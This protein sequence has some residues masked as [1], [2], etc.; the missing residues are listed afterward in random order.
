MKE[1]SISNKGKID[2]QKS[3]YSPEIS[4]ENIQSIKKQVSSWPEWKIQVYLSNERKSV[5]SQ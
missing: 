3:S 5:K 4:I 1:S 2:H